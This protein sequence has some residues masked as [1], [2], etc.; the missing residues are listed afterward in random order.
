MR[1]AHRQLYNRLIAIGFSLAV[2]IFFLWMLLIDNAFIRDLIHRLDYI[3]YDLR[4]QMSL[5]PIES[6]KNRDLIRVID[7]DEKSLSEQGRWPWSRKKMAELVKILQDNGVVVIAYDII[8]SEREANI[9][10]LVSENLKQK[11]HL[12]SEADHILNEITKDFAHDQIF[13]TALEKGDHV[14]GFL[15]D[16]ANRKMRSYTAPIPEFTKTAKSAG[17]VTTIPDKDGVI[18]R[19][20][21]VLRYKNGVYGALSL[22]A[23][24]KYLLIDSVK[25]IEAA[26]GS[27]QLIEAIQFGD[28]QIPTDEYG[29]VLIPY[30]GPEKS[31]ITFSATNVLKH[32]VDK[33]MLENTI[34]FIGSSALGLFD[35]KP[36]P[37]Q[38]VYPGVEVHASVA[39]GLLNKNFHYRP[40]W[41]KGADFMLI[42]TIG[43]LLALLLPF[44][45]PIMM[46]VSTAMV[47][48]L[49]IAG[50]YWLWHVELLD[51]PLSLSIMTLFTLGFSNVTYG[52]LIERHN[53]RHIESMFSQYVPPAHITELLQ[54]D[55]SETGFAGDT[56]EMTVLF[57]DICSFTTISEGMPAGD[58]KKMLNVFFTEMTDIIFKHNGTIDKYVGDMVMAFWGA[59]LH[60]DTHSQDALK[61]A[62]EMQQK[63]QD[64]KPK[65][66]EL[67]YP[68]INV[69]IGLNTGTMNVGDM[70]S[71]Y[72][73]NY[74][75]LGDAV[76]LGSRVE[77][78]SRFYHVTTVI[79]EF[80]QILC[81][82][83]IC[84]RLDRIRVKGKKQPITIYEPIC[85]QDQ[86]STELLR[87]IAHYETGLQAYFNQH[88]TQA[89][90]IF[91]ELQ[92]QNP[93]VYVY[94]LYLDRSQELEATPPGPDWDGVY[95]FTSK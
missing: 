30:I 79:T 34:V 7:I 82:D 45:S 1:L 46:V 14:L 95:T 35:L 4:L 65:F 5:P 94:Q 52:F 61:A 54:G 23:V 55:E 32:R 77:G 26:A 73:R 90:T 37:I 51:M 44:L 33:K 40:A 15:F 48:A 49:L 47:L 67:G 56:R 70:G 74:T 24:A 71:V 81:P 9:A 6:V 75:V 42:A 41:A 62:I 19:T 18:R 78:S 13:E 20:P 89:R 8:F 28:Y 39:A 43:V 21:L 31:F 86:A 58:L 27:Q 87:E 83:F 63:V 10:S 66:Q 59:P 53:K 91:S 29:Q 85:H 38:Q 3:A 84:R 12:S 16:T 25:P 17:F 72:R 76:N 60:S 22:N 11:T 36:T 68:E 69:G 92:A 64:L 50:D 88:W 57:M 2:T 93:E 80:C